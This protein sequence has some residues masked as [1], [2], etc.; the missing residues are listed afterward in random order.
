MKKDYLIQL[1]IE[2]NQGSPHENNIIR[3]IVWNDKEI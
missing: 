2:W 3:E 1:A